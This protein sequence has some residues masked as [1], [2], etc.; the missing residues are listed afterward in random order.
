[1]YGFKIYVVSGNDTFDEEFTTDNILDIAIDIIQ[2]D[3][4]PE[5]LGFLIKGLNEGTLS[6]ENWYFLYDESEMVLLSD[7]PTGC[8]KEEEPKEENEFE[9]KRREDA[10]NCDYGM[11]EKHDNY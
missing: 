6:D 11:N 7:M 1:M 10:N 9:K 4:L 2:A 3:T 5:M 8:M